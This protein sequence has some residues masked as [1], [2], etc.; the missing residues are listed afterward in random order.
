MNNIPQ[1]R[2][3]ALQLKDE[4]IMQ[5]LNNETILPHL[6][7]VYFIQM[8]GLRCIAVMS[9]LICHWITYNVVAMIPLGSMGV[10]LFFVL[11]GFLITR[12]LLISKEENRGR[13]ISGEIKRFYIRRTLRIFPIYYFVII[14]LAIKNFEPVREDLAWLLTYTF[15]IKFALPSV[16]ESGQV[17]SIAHLWSLSVEEQFYLFFPFLIFSIPKR[18]I[19]GFLYLLILAGLISRSLCLILGAPQNSI[20]VLTTNCSDAF[21]I[22]ALLAYGFLYEPELVQKILRKNYLYIIAVLL[23]IADLIYSRLYIDN[24]KECRTI[25]ERFL[26]S[27]CCF[28]IVGKAAFSDYKGITKKF[29][30]NRIVIYIGRIS[31]GMYIYHFFALPIWVNK[32]PVASAFSNATNHN[33]IAEAL[34]LFILTL[35][36]SSIS[37]K[38]I[39]QPINNLKN[40][41]K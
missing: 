10:N 37:W 9:V 12:I 17:N 2:T 11:S 24:Y 40:K 35:I 27:V 8:D 5:H 18:R 25:M 41:F 13:S 22:G 33:P 36:V 32:S 1:N 23:F 30:E 14:I 19:K 20:Y 26:F 29:L 39:E 6:K 16:W 28:W 3:I 7:G 31:Y 38:L 4:P 34:L 21:G 15:N